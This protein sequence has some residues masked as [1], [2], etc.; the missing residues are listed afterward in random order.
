MASN[1]NN[2]I[3]IK[4]LRKIAIYLGIT[5]IFLIVI[6]IFVPELK[7]TS[8]EI[9]KNAN[10]VI[11]SPV[12]GSDEYPILLKG[13]AYLHNIFVKDTA[14]LEN[15]VFY[16]LKDN[17]NDILSEGS[18][19]VD[20]PDGA[21]FGNFSKKIYYTEPKSKNGILKVFQISAT[22][23][24]EINVVE[25]FV[26]F[27]S[28]EGG[29]ILKV[30]F[31]NKNKDPQGLKCEKTY[32]INRKIPKDIS[33]VDAALA[34]LLNGPT[35]DEIKEGFFSS[36]PDNVN[37]KLVIIDNQSGKL[38]VDFDESLMAGVGGSCRVLSMKSQIENTLKQ[39]ENVKEVIITINGKAQGVFEP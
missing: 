5:I 24:S 33:T 28:F 21:Q 14:A 35:N 17:E 25:A 16:R 4:K 27:P 39:F 20:A 7:I 23:G 32:Y 37:V 6:L 3:F 13:K 22:D 31:G 10:I 30:Y 9:S 2:L 11:E 38:T 29:P 15:V 12:N 8:N 18:I 26:N 34:F 1:N 36:L 19:K